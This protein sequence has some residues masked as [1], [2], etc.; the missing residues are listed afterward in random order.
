[1]KVTEKHLDEMFEHGKGYA[2]WLQEQIE[3]IL[4][5][6]GFAQEEDFGENRVAMFNK[7]LEGFNNYLEK[8]V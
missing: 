4:K 3:I 6:K 8:E 2:C 5:V 7:F 1:M